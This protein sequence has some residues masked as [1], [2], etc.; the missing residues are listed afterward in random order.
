MVPLVVPQ[1][2]KLVTAKVTLGAWDT[3]CEYPV[4]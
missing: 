2:E 1:N 4:K 3:T